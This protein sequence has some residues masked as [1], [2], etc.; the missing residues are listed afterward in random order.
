MTE[1]EDLEFTETYP[2]SKQQAFKILEYKCKADADFTIRHKKG[3][4]KNRNRSTKMSP[5]ELK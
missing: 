1:L 3:R 4:Q 2:I 5:A